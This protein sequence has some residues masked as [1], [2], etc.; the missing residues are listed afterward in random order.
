M[1]DNFLRDPGGL[2]QRIEIDTRLDADFIAHGD[3]ILGADIARRA[4]V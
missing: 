1:S 4:L 2:D 3:E